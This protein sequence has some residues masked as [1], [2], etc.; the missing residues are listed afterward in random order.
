MCNAWGVGILACP[1]H[2]VPSSPGQAVA[3]L[4]LLAALA[5]WL[6]SAKK[7]FM[8]SHITGGHRLQAAGKGF[9]F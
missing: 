6:L 9:G 1:L 2:T 7:S 4:L 3:L 5:F 8:Y